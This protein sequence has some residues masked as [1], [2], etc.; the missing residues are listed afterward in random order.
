MLGKDVFSF[1]TALAWNYLQIDLKQKYFRF[2]KND[3]WLCLFYVTIPCESQL[4]S[5]CH[6]LWNWKTYLFWF[7]TSGLSEIDTWLKGN[8]VSL[9]MFFAWCRPLSTVRFLTFSDVLDRSKWPK[10]EG[11]V[12]EPL[13]RIVKGSSHNVFVI[14]SG[15]ETV[16]N[17]VNLMIDK[18]TIC[19]NFFDCSWR[20][21]FLDFDCLRDSGW[22]G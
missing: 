12:L 7:K 3:K 13:P 5:V 20:N 9:Y 17:V 19:A 18:Q 6:D 4:L 16:Q 22:S 21:F 10:T 15:H 8:R 2:Q 1:L 11:L 14:F